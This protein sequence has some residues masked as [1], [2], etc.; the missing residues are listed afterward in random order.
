[1]VGHWAGQGKVGLPLDLRAMG[2]SLVVKNLGHFKRLYSSIV[3]HAL[4]LSR[5][6]L[7]ENFYT[8]TSLLPL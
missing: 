3:F 1:M 8:L 7:I 2:Y 4:S 5:Q 6:P